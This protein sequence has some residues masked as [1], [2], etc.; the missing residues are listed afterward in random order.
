MNSSSGMRPGVAG[1]WSKLTLCGVWGG[2]GG[3]GPAEDGAGDVSS[4]TAMML[5]I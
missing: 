3:A 4:A 5:L 2:V 1:D